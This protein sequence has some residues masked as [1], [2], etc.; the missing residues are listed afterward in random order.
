MLKVCFDTAENP[1]HPNWRQTV[2]PPLRVV[3]FF[4][5]V[6]MRMVFKRRGFTVAFILDCGWY[7]DANLMS[8]AVVSCRHKTLRNCRP[9]SVVTII[10]NLNP[11]INIITNVR[12]TFST[13][14]QL[15][16]NECTALVSSNTETN[17]D[18]PTKTTQQQQHTGNVQ[19][20]MVEVFRNRHCEDFRRCVSVYLYTFP[21]SQVRQLRPYGETS[22]GEP[23][24]ITVQT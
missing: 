5:Y 15:P 11:A 23:L 21:R 2:Y 9:L 14:V 17:R 24:F 10:G 16:A 8:S 3:R 7:A 6:R 19:M 18:V 22:L 20:E 12:R 1:K 4:S 13:E